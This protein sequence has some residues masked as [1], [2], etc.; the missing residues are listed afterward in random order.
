MEK[1]HCQGSSDTAAIDKRQTA[2]STSLQLWLSFL[3][4]TERSCFGSSGT[5]NKFA[6]CKAACDFGNIQEI[7]ET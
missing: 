4:S 2:V 3:A 1:G 7:E 6:D 5:R